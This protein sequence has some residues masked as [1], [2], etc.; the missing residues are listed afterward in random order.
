MNTNT[1]I[2]MV[3][4]NLALALVLFFVL[5]KNYFLLALYAI[6]LGA[7]FYHLPHLQTL[8]YFV[9]PHALIALL[10]HVLTMQEDVRKKEGAFNTIIKTTSGEKLLKSI[11]RGVSI[12]GSAGS[13]KTLSVI[14]GFLEHF[15]KFKFSGVVYDYKN[16]ELSELLL[17]HFGKERVRIIAPHRPE[18][19]SRVN[20]INPEMLRDELSINEVAKVI[21]LNLINVNDKSDFFLQTAEALLSGVILKFKLEHPE[22]CTFP[23]I[24]AFLTT[25]DFGGYRT[26]KYIENGEEKDQLEFSEF[27]Q[28]EDFLTEN[29]RVSIQASSFIKGLASER[30]TASVISTLLNALRQFSNPRFFWVFSGNDFTFN[31]NHE[32]NRLIVSVLNDP[33]AEMSVTPLVASTIHSITKA[34]MQRD[35]DPAFFI[36]DEG[37]TIKLL[38]MARIPATMRSFGICTIYA[39][40]DITQGIVQY[41]QQQFRQILANLSI[42][43]F[44]KTNDPETANFYEKYIELYEK[45]NI[46]RTKDT[47]AIFESTKSI[48]VSVRE[49]RKIRANEFMKLKQGEFVKITEGESE[50][51][52]FKLGDI[53]AKP[54]PRYDISD[55][56]IRLNFETIIKEA[57]SLTK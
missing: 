42:Q 41:G 17:N 30:Q 31:I 5:K 15:K 12:F 21:L 49:E 38:N 27:K 13:G 23:H 29:K 54:M 16:G 50:K 48:N 6:G 1:I 22:Y 43:I 47:G 20:F 36:M 46:S 33:D 26:I 19:S 51:V 45:E 53:T 52:T 57:N 18:I 35:K 9:I 8:Y 56:E 7:V 40:Q 24:C 55:S 3:L 10:A 37:A 11:D 4:I 14:N 44:G 32:D 39:T 2:W 25:N 34:M 28:L